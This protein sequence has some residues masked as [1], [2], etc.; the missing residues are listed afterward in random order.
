LV[1]VPDLSEKFVCLGR[2]EVEFVKK[3]IV[4]SHGVGIRLYL[5]CE[6]ALKNT[7]AKPIFKMINCRRVVHY[8]I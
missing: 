8:N 6:A 2:D 4:R 5:I 1:E 3:L 7:S